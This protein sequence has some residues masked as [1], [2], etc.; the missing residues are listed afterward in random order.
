MTHLDEGAL[1]ELLDGEMPAGRSGPAEAHL[2]GCSACAAQLS[3]LRAGGERMSALLGAGDVAAPMLRAQ[4][5]FHRRRRG[6][7]PLARTGRG[8]SRAA[9]VMIAIGGAAVAAAAFPGSPVRQWVRETLLTEQEPAAPAPAPV[10][11]APAPPPEAAP[12]GVSIL[13]D[14][15]QVRVVVSGAGPELRVR[16]RLSPSPQAAVRA[17]GAAAGTARFRTA[18]GRIE[19]LNAGAGQVEVDLPAGAESAFLEVNGRVYAAK[20]GQAL[21]ALTPAVGGTADQP[22]F[23]AGP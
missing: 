10:V 14:D 18:P 5:A 6:A 1:Q 19:V 3:E 15:G 16:A 17:T 13:P 22:V 20:E 21:R 8:L 2:A 9:A 11:Q 12:T 7:H 23:R 4:A